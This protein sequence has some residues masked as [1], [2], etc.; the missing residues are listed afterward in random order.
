MRRGEKWILITIAALILFL[1]GRNAYNLATNE[2]ENTGIPFYT[3]ASQELISE[4]TLLYKRLH[5]LECHSL[6]TLKNPLRTV[7]A[8]ILDGMGSL[9]TEQWLYDYFSAPDPQQILKS[10]LKPRYRMPSYAHLSEQELR[11]LAAYMASLKVE[12]WYLDELKRAEYRKLT[13]E[14]M[15]EAP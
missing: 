1:M 8:P 2:I 15:K 3:D 14:E 13:G 5:C 11:T 9:R 7:P 4:G 6:W 12:D 10:R